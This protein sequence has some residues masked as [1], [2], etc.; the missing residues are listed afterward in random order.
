MRSHCVVIAVMI[1]ALTSQA[2]NAGNVRSLD[3]L[4]KEMQATGR[5]GMVIA[6][7]DWC[8]YC[9]Q[10]AQEMATSR[11]LRSLQRNY[12]I[13]KVNSDSAVWPRMKQVFEFNGG[14]VPAVLVFRAD[15]EQLYAQ[16]GKPNDLPAFFQRYLD[17]AGTILTSAQ[18]RE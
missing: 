3:D 12:S 7:A 6:G 16:S 4:K 13:L 9:R 10:M 5:P 14:G 2:V 18:A 1:V 11:E 8:P 17:Q 15:G